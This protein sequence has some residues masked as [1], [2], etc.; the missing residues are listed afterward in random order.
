[1]GRLHGGRRPIRVQPTKTLCDIDG[2]DLV[3]CCD[4]PVETYLAVVMDEVVK[5]APEAAPTPGAAK[6]GGKGRMTV[7]RR[8]RPAGDAE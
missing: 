2:P 4:L 3:I 6:S 1:V 7:T 8:E 5:A